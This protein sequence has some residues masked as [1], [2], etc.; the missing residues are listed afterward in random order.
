V[1]TITLKDFQEF[2]QPRIAD[3]LFAPGA[4]EAGALLT[5]ALKSTVSVGREVETSLPVYS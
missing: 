2:A 4:S 3:G 5:E 1:T